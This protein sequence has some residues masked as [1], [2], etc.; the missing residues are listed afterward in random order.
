MKVAWPFVPNCRPKIP[1]FSAMS[2]S[3]P[4]SS[5][6]DGSCIEKKLEREMSLG[7]TSRSKPSL[8]REYMEW[9]QNKASALSVLCVCVSQDDYR[10]G[11]DEYDEKV[12]V[13]FKLIL[14]ELR[15]I[16]VSISVRYCTVSELGLGDRNYHYA[17]LF[18]LCSTMTLMYC[19][20]VNESGT[21]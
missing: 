4:A 17:K 8:M 5:Y 1:V 13:S 9:R 12:F 11:V 16:Y 10:R 18:N 14:R 7:L 21:D 19:T 6:K 20:I 2:S 15:N 3:L